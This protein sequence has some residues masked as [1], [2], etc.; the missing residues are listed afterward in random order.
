M[1][2]AAIILAA[3]ESK[4]FGSENKL[5]HSLEGVPLV[6]RVTRAFEA[7]GIVRRVVVL[8]YEAE[9]VVGALSGQDLDFVVNE[10]FAKGMGT[11]VAAGAGALEDDSVDGVLLCVG[12]L[13]LLEG[14][15]VQKVC[16]AFEERDGRSVVVPAFRE[17]P[18]HPVC[19]PASLLPEL[20]RLKGDEGA[21]RVI[22]KCGL[23]V[24][25]IEMED[26]KCVEDLDTQ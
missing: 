18:G 11:S 7:P 16:S 23:P 5:L 25:T 15:V 26:E 9:R 6:A 21:R 2:F 24:V 17:A 10:V 20:R 19:V 13:P 22:R 4:R 8:G 14:S 3:G 12:D 1:R